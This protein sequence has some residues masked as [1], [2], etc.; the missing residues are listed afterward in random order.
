MANSHEKQR[1]LKMRS[2]LLALVALS[3][4]KVLSDLG[5]VRRLGEDLT[6]IRPFSLSEPPPMPEDSIERYLV[7]DVRGGLSN[8]E[9][10]IREAMLLAQHSQRHLVLPRV[11][12]HIPKGKTYAGSDVPFYDLN[13]LWNVDI[14]IECACKLGISVV[15]AD[16]LPSN[17][18]EM[19]YYANDWGGLDSQHPYTKLQKETIVY[20]A[21]E[22]LMSSKAQVVHVVAPFRLYKKIPELR[23]VSKCLVPSDSILARVNEVTPTGPY[24]CLHARVEQDW[25]LPCCN[26]GETNELDPDDPDSWRC[27]DHSR[28]PRSCYSTPRQ[29][30]EVLQSYG[31]TNQAT[32]WVASGVSNKALQ[33]LF[34]VFDVRRMLSTE[35]GNFMDYDIALVQREV[36]GRSIRTWSQ[37]G[38]SFTCSMSNPQS[39]YSQKPPW[40]RGICSE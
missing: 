27:A 19:Y 12:T 15:Q 31:V 22:P 13:T 4:S 35:T 33:P 2:W 7:V 40:K 23:Q 25:F 38:T 28:P 24:I 36:C 5:L 1:R 14:F 26:K 21:A 6:S 34:D 39:V 32:V 29:I 16:E 17:A 9:I 20:N 3:S 11:R 18:T 30:A 10:M 8:Q 37:A